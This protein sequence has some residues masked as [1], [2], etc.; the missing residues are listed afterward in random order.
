[1][2]KNHEFWYEDKNGNQ[3]PHVVF[4]GDRFCR[5]ASMWPVDY[6]H[7]RFFSVS[8]YTSPPSIFTHGDINEMVRKCKEAGIPHVECG[9]DFPEFGVCASFNQHD[10][11]FGSYRWKEI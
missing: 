8:I 9:Y 11:N 3:T 2:A 6:D 7:S 10:R 1:M 5:G 4:D